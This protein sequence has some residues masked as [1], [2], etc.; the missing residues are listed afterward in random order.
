MLWLA[1]VVTMTAFA[2]CLEGD[3]PA[4]PNADTPPPVV[5]PA[6]GCDAALTA[7]W[8][9]A[10]GAQA[11]GPARATGIACLSSTAWRGYEPSLGVTSDGSIFVYP[12]WHDN[13]LDDGV[14]DRLTGM[15]VARTSDGGGTWTRHTSD[16][17]PANYHPFTADPFMYVDPYTDRVFIE[18]LII[19]P[20]NCANLSFSDDR[21]E[22]WTQSL[23][24]CLV[25]DH[26]SYAAG[27]PVTS[28]L[29]G[30]PTVVQRCAITYVLTTLASEATGCQ[31]SL[32]GGMTW[33]PPGDPAFLFG[34]D[35]MPYVPSTCHGAAHH[36]FVDHRGWTWLARD[37]CGQG[38][39]V[40]ISK[41]EGATWAQHKISDASNA[42]HDVG[43]GADTA[44][45]AYA[46]WI[47]ADGRPLLAA[48]HDDGVTWEDPIDIAPPGLVAAGNPSLVP[49]GA[50]K[51]AITYAANFDFDG[52]ESVHGVVVAAYD[53]DTD[54][55]TFHTALVNHPDEPLADGRCSAMCP[56]QADFLTATLGPDGAPY[57]SFVRSD[58]SRVSVGW[59]AGA[60]SLWDADDPNGRY[61]DQAAADDQSLSSSPSRSP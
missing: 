40:A 37:W 11:T 8:H 55:P 35:G 7:T 29:E 28:Q 3:D 48:S 32:D 22:T 26:V 61:P 46:F 12:T 31:K 36:V 50:G 21:G 30:Y 43:I 59:L 44:G 42:H 57:G 52:G 5:E 38:Q 33:Q 13:G 4:A 6:P 9:T 2:G 49:G 16:I 51:A 18:D 1:L 47:D 58:G 53:L 19:P 10:G 25:W 27:P 15:G 20:F 54:Q 17:G 60:P 41:D 56:G 14:T 24:G 23:A 45:T 39:W 34:P